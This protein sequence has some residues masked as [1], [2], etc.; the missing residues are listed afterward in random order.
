MRVVFANIIIILY[1]C[2]SR[3]IK[4]LNQTIKHN[5]CE[6]LVPWNGHQMMAMMAT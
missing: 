4:P 5:E 2:H 3:F 1:F 6:S